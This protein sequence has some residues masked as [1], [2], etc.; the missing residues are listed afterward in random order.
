MFVDLHN[1]AVQV[2]IIVC[3]ALLVYVWMRL[4]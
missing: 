4:L 2:V 1:P 3:V